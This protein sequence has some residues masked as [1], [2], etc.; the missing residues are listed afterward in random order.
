ML[1][2]KIPQTPVGADLSRPSPIYRPSV[3]FH[4]RKRECHSSLRSESRRPARQILHGVYTERSE[5]AQND[6]AGLAC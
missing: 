1:I 4:D 5:C 6:T 2:N 3:A